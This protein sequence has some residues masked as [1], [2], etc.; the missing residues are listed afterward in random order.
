MTGLLRIINRTIAKPWFLAAVAVFSL[1]LT[2]FTTAVDSKEHKTR[3]RRGFLGSE[4]YARFLGRRSVAMAESEVVRRESRQKPNLFLSL[5]TARARDASN[6]LVPGDL[7]SDLYLALEEGMDCGLLMLGTDGEIRLF[8]TWRRAIQEGIIQG[9]KF[10]RVRVLQNGVVVYGISLD[11]TRVD[12]YLN[13][14]RVKGRYFVVGVAPELRESQG[15]DK[16]TMDLLEMMKTTG[17]G[18]P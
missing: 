8:E 11:G 9:L 1:L 14:A 6:T 12:G 18:T 17:R 4:A 10:H 3:A 5:K 2:F 15:P 16:E 7:L 13:V